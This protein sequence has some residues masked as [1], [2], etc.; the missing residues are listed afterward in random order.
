M[1][2]GLA[3]TSASPFFVCSESS[4]LAALFNYRTLKLRCSGNRKLRTVRQKSQKSVSRDFRV[5]VCGEPGHWV[6]NDR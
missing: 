5:H 6:K 1:N 4:A 2:E 3:V